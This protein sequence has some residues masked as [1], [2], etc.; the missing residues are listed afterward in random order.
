MIAKK[1]K[2]SRRRNRKPSNVARNAKRR[3]IRSI[4]KRNR[5]TPGFMGAT[6]DFSIDG[7]VFGAG[8]LFFGRAPS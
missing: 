1:S 4:I 3:L 6:T 2:R 8:A 5:G 7:K